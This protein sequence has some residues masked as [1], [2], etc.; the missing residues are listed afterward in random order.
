M[1]KKLPSLMQTNLAEMRLSSQKYLFR[2]LVELSFCSA[3]IFHG[4][5][6]ILEQITTSSSSSV[7][8]SPLLL[9]YLPKLNPSC[10]AANCAAT[11]EI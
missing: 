8:F 9:T 5:F 6:W 10:E 11:K 3:H 4:K 7:P 2:I 1:L